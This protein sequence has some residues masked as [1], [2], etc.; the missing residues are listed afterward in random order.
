M[1]SAEKTELSGILERTERALANMK[2]DAEQKLFDAASKHNKELNEQR[3]ELENGK[4][5]LREELLGSR[6]KAR[7]LLEQKDELIESSGF[8]VFSM[9]NATGVS[10]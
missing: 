9:A 1:D 2:L 10:R 5:A 8:I 3:E 4:S 6:K 7:E